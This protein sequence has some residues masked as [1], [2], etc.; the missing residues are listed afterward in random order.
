MIFEVKSFGNSS[1][2][3]LQAVARWVMSKGLLGQFPLAKELSDWVEGR[4]RGGE[5]E[6]E[7]EG[8]DSSDDE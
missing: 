4:E 7:G 6:D 8:A 3:G 2:G 1:K 5:G